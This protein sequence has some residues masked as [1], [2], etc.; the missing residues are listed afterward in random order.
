[1]TAWAAC[2]ALWF[3]LISASMKST[4]ACRSSG[5]GGSGGNAPSLR[6]ASSANRKGFIATNCSD[7][8][9]Y[10]LIR[11][12]IGTHLVPLWFPTGTFSEVKAGVRAD[13]TDQY[14]ASFLRHRGVLGQFQPSHHCDSNPEKAR[15]SCS[16]SNSGLP[17]LH[18]LPPRSGRLCQYVKSRAP[19]VTP[20]GLPRTHSP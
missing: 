18:V 14:L 10:P 7:G 6:R 20:R 9:R 13:C 1:M 8:A 11:F 3:R 17:L 5:D 19:A 12:R 15:V 16:T 4:Q 2:A